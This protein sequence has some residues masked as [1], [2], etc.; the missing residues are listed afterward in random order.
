MER[1]RGEVNLSP[2]GHW[3]VGNGE[4]GTEGIQGLWTEGASKPPVAQRAGG[5]LIWE[6]PIDCLTTL[7]FTLFVFPVAAKVFFEALLG[8]MRPDGV[9]LGLMGFLQPV[10]LASSGNKFDTT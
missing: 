4:R 9:Q 10:S 5:I 8:A 7:P 3:D 1:G 6:C 2:R